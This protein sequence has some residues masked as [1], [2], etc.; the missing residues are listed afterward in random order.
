M[1]A[2]SLRDRDAF[3]SPSA[4]ITYKYKCLEM[5]NMFKGFHKISV[6]QSTSVEN[7]II[8]VLQT[9]ALASRV[10]S[11]SAAMALWSCCGR[12]TSLLQG[13]NYQLLFVYEA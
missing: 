7:G 9:F 1:S 12:R 6:L 8:S 5:L 3:I 10:A 13:E 2:A 11:A 4:A